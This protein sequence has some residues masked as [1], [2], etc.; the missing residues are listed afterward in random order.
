MRGTGGGSS[1]RPGRPGGSV[2][3]AAPGGL[4][5]S[6]TATDALGPDRFVGVS[7]EAHKAALR[8]MYRVLKPESLPLVDAMW[9]RFG[10]G[11]WAALARKYPEVDM[12]K[13]MCLHVTP[14][15][16]S[17]TPA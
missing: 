12:A 3:P 7:A 17:C 15:L 16:R 11:V 2:P 13:V 5:S 1:A 9:S 10:D 6:S 8:R 14:A 4:S